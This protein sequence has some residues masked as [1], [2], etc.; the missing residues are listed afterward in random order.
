M[1]LRKVKNQ[2]S[3]HYNNILVLHVDMYMIADIKRDTFKTPI[4]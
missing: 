1:R 3:A 4:E 2:N